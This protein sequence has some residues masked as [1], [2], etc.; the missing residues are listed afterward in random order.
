MSSDSLLLWFH[1]H[2]LRY[3]KWNCLEF[4]SC[5]GFV[6]CLVLFGLS[7]LQTDCS[8]WNSTDTSN[9][10]ELQP[11]PHS[12]T[13]PLCIRNFASGDP[14]GSVAVYLEVKV[15]RGL[16]SLSANLRLESSWFRVRVP[17]WE[18]L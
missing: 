11:R 16:P 4:V 18:E 9:Y 6:N 12:A 8:S 13:A 5:L 7:C 15:V 17:E 3:S 14:P 2:C 1:P 10:F